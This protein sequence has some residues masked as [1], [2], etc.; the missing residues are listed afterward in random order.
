VAL[1][2]KVD[3]L[4]DAFIIVHVL[5]LPRADARSHP[6][7]AGK[8][9]TN[10]TNERKCNIGGAS[11]LASRTRR[12]KVKRRR[13]VGASPHRRCRSNGVGNFWFGFLQRC[14]AYGAGKTVLII[15]SH[16]DLR[17]QNIFAPKTA[18]FYMEQS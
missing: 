2:Q 4:G 18:T 16:L 8:L 17:S 15:Q 10:C 1:I 13:L 7:L 5:T 11:V 3:D 9:D 14:R 12:A 6:F